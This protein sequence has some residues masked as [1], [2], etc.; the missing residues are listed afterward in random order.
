MKRCYF[1]AALLFVLLL[2]GLGTT[3]AI[4]R[5]QMPVTTALNAASHAARQRE[6]EQLEHFVR[7]AENQWL[8][9]RK[10]SAAL[11]D[12]APIEAV[13]SL[14]AQIS[15]LIQ[16]EEWD[17]VAAL[18]AQLSSQ[19]EAIVDAHRLSWWNLL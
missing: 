16:A 15:P 2:T 14:F 5:C 1:G 12:H 19:V 10:F 18:C 13:D 9:W 7:D 8:R 11:V 17:T 3:W 6:P 4:S